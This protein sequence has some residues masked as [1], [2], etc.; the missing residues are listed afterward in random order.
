MVRGVWSVLTV[1]AG[2]GFAGSYAGVLHPLGD[3]LAVF[4]LPLAMAFGIGVVWTGWPRV[5]RWP[6]AALCLAALAAIW[7]PRVLM[8]AASEHDWT[9]YQQNLLYNRKDDTALMAEVAA[10]QPDFMTLQEVS[11]ANR[12]LV[13]D[14]PGEFLTQVFCPGRSVGGTAVLS[15]YP[16]VPGTETCATPGGGLA[17]VQVETE[18][19]RVWLVSLHLLWPYPH[20]QAGH[21]D[22]LVPVLEALEGPVILG[23]DFNAVAWSHA[24]R[25]IEAATGTT[26]IGPFRGTFD[27]PFVNAPIGIDHVLTTNRAAQEVAVLPKLGSDHHG[28]IAY[29]SAP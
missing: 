19:G 26:M 24:V 16:A 4:R 25:R 23:G 12:A 7:L 11:M 21:L 22:R 10:R 1:L 29:L 27:L 17:A 14:M 5:V 2:I 20:G 15:R 6:L 18:H 9:L 8:P 3:S 13:D 28:V